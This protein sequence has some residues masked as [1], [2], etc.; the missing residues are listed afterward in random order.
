MAIESAHQIFR[1]TDRE[2]WLITAASEDA[3]C[4]L[5]ATF[6]TAASIA[7][8]CPRM[9]IGLDKAH[10]TC[11]TIE[12]T[13]AFAAHLLSERYLYWVWQFGLQSSREVDK[14]EGLTI[15]SAQTGSPI[16]SEALAWLDCRVET[17]MDIGDRI[18]F[19]GKV[20]DSGQSG[21]EPPLTI[22]RLMKIA[23]KDKLKTLE[24]QMRAEAVHDAEDIRRWRALGSSF[25]HPGESA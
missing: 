1:S 3:R 6:V 21:S 12:R 25:A 8:D 20:V 2:L 14:F 16:L 22:H 24:D 13:G 5:I 4:G 17:Q 10:E 15:N 9:L 11:R 19:L 7:P 23:P 18:V